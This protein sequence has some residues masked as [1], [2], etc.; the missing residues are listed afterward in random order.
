[1]VAD[2]SEGGCT[3]FAPVYYNAPLRSVIATDAT[4]Q[5][6]YTLSDAFLIVTDAATGS[7]L[8]TLE[9]E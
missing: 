5:T 2:G 6:L 8:A 1:P 3:S 7:E 9:F 4:S